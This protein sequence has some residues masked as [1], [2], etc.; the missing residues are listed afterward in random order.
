MKWNLVSVLT[1]SSSTGVRDKT[2]RELFE[3]YPTFSRRRP[4]PESYDKVTNKICLKIIHTYNEKLRTY[5]FQVQ[6]KMESLG[7]LARLNKDEG[8]QVLVVQTVQFV[9]VPYESDNLIIKSVIKTLS[10]GFRF[11]KLKIKFC[12]LFGNEAGEVLVFD[13]IVSVQFYDWWEPGYT[14]A[15]NN[16]FD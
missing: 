12:D 8:C 9:Q 2:I 5:V 13:P 11:Y 6:S 15:L 16:G 1:G 4:D 3:S 14:K 10:R 7:K